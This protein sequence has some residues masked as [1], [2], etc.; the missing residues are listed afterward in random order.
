M[1]LLVSRSRPHGAAATPDRA[2]V[3]RGV[4]RR[5][6]MTLIETLIAVVILG[7][8]LVALGQF[9]SNFAHATRAAGLQ[10]RAIDLASDR[11][12][13]VRHSPTY[14]SIDS[15]AGSKVV[16][17]DSTTYLVQTLVQLIGGSPTDTV[18]YKIITVAVSLPALPKPL[19]KTTVITAF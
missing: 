11:I 4:V 14:A 17:A 10:Q 8:A 15:M 5:R 16:T 12:D 19:R 9:M 7:T 1:P 2:R 3:R 6:G 13:S 18:D